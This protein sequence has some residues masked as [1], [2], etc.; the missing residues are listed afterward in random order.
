M[1]YPEVTTELG[2]VSAMMMMMNGKNHQD[3]CHDRITANNSVF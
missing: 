1:S 2:F 3:D